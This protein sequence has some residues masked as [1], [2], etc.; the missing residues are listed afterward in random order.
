M[1]IPA[2]VS[3]GSPA[4]WWGGVLALALCLT[5]CGDAPSQD[6]DPVLEFALGYEPFSTDETP[7][8]G[9]PEPGVE[10]AAALGH[11]PL[12]AETRLAVALVGTRLYRYHVD[13]FGQSYELR[14]EQPNP[15]VSAFAVLSGRDLDRLEF[16]PSRAIYEWTISQEDLAS[17]PLIQ[18]ETTRIDEALRRER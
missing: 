7:V 8:P 10:V 14:Q 2:C 1:L 3:T 16:L 4:L 12:P 15:I 11:R 17:D 6:A 13:C 18:R 9:L 5:A